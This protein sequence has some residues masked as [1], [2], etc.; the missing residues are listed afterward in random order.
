M[1]SDERLAEVLAAARRASFRHLIAEELLSGHLVTFE[2]FM[3]DGEVTPS[4]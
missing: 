2:G 1:D 3:H 4:A